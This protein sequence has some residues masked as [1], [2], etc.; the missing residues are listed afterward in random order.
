[1]PAFSFEYPWLLLLL[2]FGLLLGW[3]LGRRRPLALRYPDVQVFQGLPTGGAVVARWGPVVLR[4]LA[5]AFTV[6]AAANPRIPDLRTPIRVEGIAFVLVLD[7]SSS[8]NT[9]DFDPNVIPP[10]T[11]LDA[12][13]QTVHHFVL[14]GE[15]DGA[16]FDG[17][18]NDQLAL[19]TFA[20]VADTACPLTLN[21]TV[22]LQ[23][24]NEQQAKSGIDAGTNIG[25][26]LGEGLV[27]LQHLEK[28]LDKR[29]QVL[30]LLSDGE[31]NVADKLNPLQSAQLAATLGI[32]IYTIDCGG[33]GSTGNAEE[34]KQRDDGRAVMEQVAN[35]TG[36]KAFVATNQRELKEAFVQID[37]LE[38]V[39]ATK[40]VYRRYHPFGPWCGLV[41]VGVV[42]VLG[43]LERTHWRRLP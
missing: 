29:R 22:F 33:D 36:G 1:M 25:D 24:L 8:M 27:R 11:R 15:A 41:A 19:V 12:A 4:G 34:R 37:Q 32:P 6:L 20:A 31:H 40:F 14:G 2:P 7:V 13:K 28:A 38:K 39:P 23:V 35:L 16:R 42:L 30:V 17:R 43:F 18:T 3:W 9:P 10:V 21:H 26:A 5:V